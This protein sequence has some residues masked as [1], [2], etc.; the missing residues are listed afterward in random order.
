[1]PLSKKEVDALLHL[2]GITADREINCEQCLSVVAEFAE[3]ELKGRPISEGRRAVEHHL[4]ICA[5]CHEEYETLLR[6][7]DVINEIAHD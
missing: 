7:L 6:T 2:V 3:T 1:M 5:E 4:S